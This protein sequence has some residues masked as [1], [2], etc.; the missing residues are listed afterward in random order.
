MRMGRPNKFFPFEAFIVLM[1]CIERSH[2]L[3]FHTPDVWNTFSCPTNYQRQPRVLLPQLHPAHIVC[4]NESF[5]E[6]STHGRIHTHCQ[7]RT[8]ITLGTLLFRFLCCLTV[9]TEVAGKSQLCGGIRHSCSVRNSF[10]VCSDQA[11]LLT[12]SVRHFF[13]AYCF[14][15]DVLPQGV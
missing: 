11:F 6:D 4:D 12:P 9:R 13:L 1:L 15:R 14:S 2:S 3:F 5:V 7:Q 10:T 8:H